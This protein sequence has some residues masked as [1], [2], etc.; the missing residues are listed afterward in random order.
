MHA[1]ANVGNLRNSSGG[2]A[3]A[4]PALGSASSMMG[5]ST[6]LYP[7]SSSPPVGQMQSLGGVR[8]A[9]ACCVL[10]AIADHAGPGGGTVRLTVPQKRSMSFAAA[11][12]SSAFLHGAGAVSVSSGATMP[13]E[14]FASPRLSM[15]DISGVRG[16]SCLPSQRRDRGPIAPRLRAMRVQR[17]MSSL[18][19]NA[20]GLP[21]DEALVLKESEV[22]FRRGTRAAVPPP[23]RLP[24]P[25]LRTVD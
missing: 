13:P 4:T 5:S 24:S 15:D 3:L 19:M 1:L 23:C 20:V 6:A 12:G 25:R 9:L 14:A 18:R 11:G 16:R 21:G 8:A 2:T 7:Y 22:A 17:S 10:A